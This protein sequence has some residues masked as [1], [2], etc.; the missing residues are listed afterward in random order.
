MTEDETLMLM[1]TALGP[2][3]FADA[4]D[5]EERCWIIQH[6]ELHK[7]ALLL[8]RESKMTMRER[9]VKICEST[10]GLEA[11]DCAKLIRAEPLE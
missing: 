10:G 8:K 2:E 6:E 11:Q 9:C 1:S 5:P 7:F 3:E 4:W